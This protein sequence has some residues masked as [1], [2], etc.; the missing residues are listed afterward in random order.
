MATSNKNEV[1][2]IGVIAEDS[3]DVDVINE[4]LK[5]FS[6]ANKFQIKK[7]VGNGC[8]KLRNK[9]QSWADALINKGCTHLLV[10]HDLDRNK[11][12]ELLSVLQ[13]KIPKAKYPNAL[14]VI[15][16]EELEAWLLS[17]EAAIQSV[18]SLKEPPKKYKNC[19]EIK[20]PK[21]E[22]ARLVWS[23]ATKRYLNTVHN[24][25]LAEKTSLENFRRCASFKPLDEYLK[26]SIFKIN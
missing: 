14:I 18:F 8:G 26:E 12:S 19:E 10:V 23:K 17:D 7:F 15:P 22:L 2:S 21:E 1:H 13:S 20:S 3:S 9:C 16:I 11:E 5:K 25:K 6:P 24:K 4:I